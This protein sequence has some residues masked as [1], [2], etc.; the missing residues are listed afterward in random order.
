MAGLPR[1]VDAGSMKPGSTPTYGRVVPCIH[2]VDVLVSAGGH[3]F[4]STV[5][6]SES[7]GAGKSFQ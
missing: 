7:S 6:L 4:E 3:C 1:F 2:R 5:N